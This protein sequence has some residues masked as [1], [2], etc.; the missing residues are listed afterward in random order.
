[1]ILGKPRQVT[2]SKS[3]WYKV[4][5]C[6]SKIGLLIILHNYSDTSFLWNGNDLLTTCLLV[7]FVFFTTLILRLIARMIYL[8]ALLNSLLN[9][10]SQWNFLVI[11]PSIILLLVYFC[12]VLHNFLWYR[13]NVSFTS[14]LR[15]RP[16]SCFRVFEHWFHRIECKSNVPFGVLSAGCDVVILIAC[17][18]GICFSLG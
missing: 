1:M 4:F 7:V 17:I 16:D 15:K 18:V 8:H 14:S 9:V 11:V 6:S 12:N 5:F 3:I 10:A 2:S 13:A